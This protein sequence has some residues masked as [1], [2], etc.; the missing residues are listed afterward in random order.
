MTSKRSNFE[1]E[2]NK[3]LAQGEKDLLEPVI[4][5]IKEENEQKRMEEYEKES[6][7]TDIEE[8]NELLDENK[9]LV[10]VLEQ[11]AKELS[12]CKDKNREEF[13]KDIIEGLK[14]DIKRNVNIQ[15][16]LLERILNH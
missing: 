15:T 12:H 10:Y 7:R 13:V 2:L 14:Q 16:Q 8:Y 6:L 1:E 9:E 5:E 4:C 11:E 3:S